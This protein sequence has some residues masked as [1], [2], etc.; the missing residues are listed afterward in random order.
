MRKFGGAIARRLAIAA[1]L[2]TAFAFFAAPAQAKWPEKPV[3]IILPFGAGGVADVTT[4]I[5]ADKLSEKLGQRFIIEN[6]P[7]AGGIQ[8]ARAVISAPP[9]GYTMGLITNGTAI[10][11]AAFNKLPFDPVKDFSMVSTLGLFDL[12]FVVNAQSSYK[13]LGDFIK[14]AKAQP[15]KLNIGTIA[16]GGT[17]NLGAELFKS[18]SGL[19]VVIVPYKNSPDIVVALLRND[20]QMLVEFPP[21]VQGQVNGGSLRILAT[22]SPKRS[23]SRPNVPTVAEAG[24]PGFE[25][26][27]WNAVFAPK[28]TPKEIVDAMNKAMREVLALPDLKAQYEKVG[29]TAQ[30]STPDELMARL[31]A[32]IVKWDDVIKKAGIPKK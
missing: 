8:A 28:G 4:R 27:S 6:M 13:T 32:D 11:V 25:V 9:D 17:Q 24:V 26:T 3:K 1:S 19:N 30:A 22:S 7:G 16:V 15:G 14:A 12:V 31:K 5:M 23:P 18:L 29:V 21:A 2:M 20:V 10:S